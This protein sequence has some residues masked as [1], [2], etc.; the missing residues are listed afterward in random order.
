[1]K[2]YKFNIG[3]RVRVKPSS[4]FYGNIEGCVIHV[5]D[6][7]TKFPITVRLDDG[8]EPMGYASDE[9]ELVIGDQD[10]YE[11]WED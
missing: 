3:D 8:Q 2:K 9:L 6:R 1:M 10:Q 5:A 7:R 11:D 4:Y